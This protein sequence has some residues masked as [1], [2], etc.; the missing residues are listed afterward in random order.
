M[1]VYINTI[2]LQMNTSVTDPYRQGVE[3]TQQKYYD[4]GFVKIFAGEPGHVIRK[5]NYGQEDILTSN[6]GYFEDQSKFDPI[7]FL[8]VQTTN[9]I[10]KLY[11]VKSIIVG[12]YDND[13]MDGAIEPLTIRRTV[14]LKSAKLPLEP[15]AIKGALQSG[16]TGHFLSSDQ[17]L[18]VDYYDTNYHTLP[19]NDT[20]SGTLLLPNS[21]FDEVQYRLNSPLMPFK[22]TNILR[23]ELTTSNYRYGG[24]IDA[25]ATMTGSGDTYIAFNKRSATCGWEFNNN[26]NIGTDSITFGGQLY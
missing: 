10:A 20:I 9:A 2:D 6:E 1:T 14:T 23:C 24:L 21:S 26:T 16:N 17:T 19:F 7:E 25:L 5:V 13:L 18:S 11:K 22:E 8:E 3:I 12:D 15:H 4:A